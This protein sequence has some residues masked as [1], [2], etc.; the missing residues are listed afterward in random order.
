MRLLPVERPKEL[1]RFEWS[2]AFSGSM[3]SFGG[4]GENYFSY[5][6]YKDLRDQNQVFTGV[7]AADRVQVGLSWHNQAESQDAEVVSGNY[8]QLLGL[9]PAAGRL[10]TPQDDTTKNANPV[11]VLSYTYWKTRFGGSHD[12]IGQS[13][14]VN[15]HPFTVLGVAPEN[16]V[17][18]I[19]GYR[20]ALFVPVN[21]VE[22]VI[23]W[24]ASLNDLTN[25][26]SVW[27]TLVARLKPGITREQ[28]ETS[29]NP[30][31]HSLRAYEL[32][33]YKSKS[34]H[35]RKN[36]LDLTHIKVLDDSKGFSPNRADIQKPLTILM[37]MAGLLVVL[38]AINVATLLLLR[39][40]RRARE[41]SMRY[42]LGAKRSR[43][44]SQLFVE[45]GLLGVCWR[46]RRTCFLRPSSLGHL[47]A[48]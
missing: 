23:P 34:E 40:A 31:W 16:F 28:A 5:P 38:C 1:V 37:S 18:A 32:T 2:G 29:L 30:L 20:P 3:S 25:H 4:D 17:S 6:M 39:A 47:S 26:Q 12:V 46:S 10:I 13:V 36:F 43:I 8:F 15:G 48:S 11:A 9:K 35:F 14:L 19:G 44:I 22:A 33:L 42:A 41:M 24:R 7:L 45:G 27:L 21:M